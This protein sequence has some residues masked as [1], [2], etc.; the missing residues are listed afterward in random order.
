MKRCGELRYVAIR[1]RRGAS[2]LIASHRLSET[3]AGGATAVVYEAQ[4]TMKNRKVA[5]KVMS[6]NKISRRSLSHRAKQEIKIAKTLVHE[7]IVKLLD[8][9]TESSRKASVWELV[10]G[11]ELLSILNQHQNGLPEDMAA[12]YFHQILQ[13]VLFMHKN[14]FAHGDLKP[15]NCMVCDSTLQLK[16]VDFGLTRGL[17]SQDL[18]F[19][20]GTPDYMAPE[21]LNPFLM[22]R[23]KGKPTVDSRAVDA[24]AM[25]VMLYL[26]VTGV[27]PFEDPNHSHRLSNTY[28]NITKGNPRKLPEKVTQDCSDLILSLLVKNPRKRA[29]LSRVSKNVWLLSNAQ[30]YSLKIFQPNLFQTLSVES[31]PSLSDGPSEIPSIG[32]FY[33]DLLKDIHFTSSRSLK[34]DTGLI[35]GS[36]NGPKKA[37][38]NMLRC[39]FSSGSVDG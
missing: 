36:L 2:V 7:N 5:I 15:E 38:G 19:G 6:S 28:W 12:F 4:D 35:Q 33:V 39:C 37:F 11:Q 27:F 18:R 14:G 23:G 16:L 10:E 34:R 29:R 3:F 13:G 1:A 31:E 24:W 20:F 22:R 8:S 26:L 32:D 9:F 17:K 21:T 25:G 30:A